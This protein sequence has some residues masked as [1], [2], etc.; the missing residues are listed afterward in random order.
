[1]NTNEMIDTLARECM[2][3]LESRDDIREI[4]WERADSHGI[5]MYPHMAL[6]FLEAA[7][8]DVTG[9]AFDDLGDLGYTLGRD[10]IDSLAD[11]YCKLAFLALGNMIAER[12][13]EILVEAEENEA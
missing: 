11:L 4:T 3:A 5:A 6:E 8:V 10:G 12:M 7:G 9:N 13:E 2:E 1:M